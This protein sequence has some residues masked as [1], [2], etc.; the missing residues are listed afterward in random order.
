M[1]GQA[2]NWTG[3]LLRLLF[4]LVLVFA[5]YNPEGYSYY[6]W[7]LLQLPAITPAKALLGVVLVIGWVVYLRATLRSL[8][9]IG[10][11]LA[12]AFF[13]TLIWLFVDLGWVSADTPRALAYLV[14]FLL[15][16]V[17]S[18]GLSWSL[19][20]RRLTGQVDVDEVDE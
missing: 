9:L 13:G 3:Y 10:L 15:S 16:A 17:L 14:L 2:L 1:S 12:G 7:T 19:I 11:A 5:S 20:R 8:G 18:I 6:H 4:A